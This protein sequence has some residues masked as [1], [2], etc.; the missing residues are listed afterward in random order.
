[1]SDGTIFLN[2]YH[3]RR[4]KM[5]KQWIAV[6]LCAGLTASQCPVSGA[7]EQTVQQTETAGQNMENNEKS[8]DIVETET[9]QETKGPEEEPETPEDQAQ[10]IQAQR[11]RI[12]IIQIQ[13]NRNLQKTGKT[14]HPETHKM[15][16]LQKK[17]SAGSGKLRQVKI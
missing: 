5:N 2:Y 10:R 9:D 15:A 11:I 8:S 17:C 4:K 3:K 14:R 13:K 6:L 1:M 12:Q 7:Q 16:R